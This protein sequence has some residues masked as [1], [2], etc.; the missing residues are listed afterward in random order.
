MLSENNLVLFP[1]YIYIL[2]KGGGSYII[3]CRIYNFKIVGWAMLKYLLF[4]G[5]NRSLFERNHQKIFNIFFFSML[6]RIEN[7]ENEMEDIMEPL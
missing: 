5:S 3:G 6:T 1:P 7:L 4:S 2:F